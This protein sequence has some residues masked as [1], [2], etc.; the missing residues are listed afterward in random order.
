MA[1]I[2]WWNR[3]GPVTLGERFGLDEIS[4]ARNTLSPTK[5]H[6]AGL[7]ESF[8][9]TFTSYNDAVSEGFQGTR[10]E[11]L[12]QQSI[13]ITERPLT[14]AEGGRIGF[15]E[16]S[17]VETLKDL[18]NKGISHEN[19]ATELDT[20]R[21]SVTRTI[22]KLKDKN[23]LEERE[24]LKVTKKTPR[25]LRNVE[26]LRG[27]LK[28]EIKEFNK[29]KILPKEKYTATLTKLAEQLNVSSRAIENYL[30][31]IKD[32]DFDVTGKTKHATGGLIPGY[33]TGGVSNFFRSR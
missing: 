15:L 14:G 27:I 21:M 2:D 3:T 28:K 17:S 23:I 4:I 30:N 16:G 10:E 11:W 19:I 26:T 18:Y 8:P 25:F 29:A 13:P 32:L 31:E 33:A 12:Q 20:S 24:I 6:T 22:K 9:G 7:S 1:Y 5:S